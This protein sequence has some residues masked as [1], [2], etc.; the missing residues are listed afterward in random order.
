MVGYP[1][2][3]DERV[4]RKRLIA[5]LTKALRGLDTIGE[6]EAAIYIDQALIVL[7][8]H[9]GPLPVDVHE[10]YLPDE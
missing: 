4:Q 9:G 8:G 3:V 2:P 7:Q 6:A 1:E 5:L 10:D